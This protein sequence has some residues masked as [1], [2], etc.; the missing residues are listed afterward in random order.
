MH[1]LKKINLESDKITVLI[2]IYEDSVAELRR[3]RDLEWKLPGWTLIL[4]SGL[5]TFLTRESVNDAVTS[6]AHIQW[7][8]TAIAVILAIGILCLYIHSQNSLRFHRDL[9][10]RIETAL[11]INSAGVYSD[12][13]ILP[14]RVRESRRFRDRVWGKLIVGAP[15]V[16]LVFLATALC[17]C[18]IWA[19]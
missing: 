1:D 5:A 6:S 10:E 2:A 4:L 8:L 19:A 18:L 3:F 16:V 17:L 13:S 15:L 14:R 11:A 12:K 7:L 9:R